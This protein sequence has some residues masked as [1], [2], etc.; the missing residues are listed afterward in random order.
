MNVI[1][2]KYIDTCVNCPDRVSAHIYAKK[3]PT[4][5]FFLV[6]YHP[7]T[8]KFRCADRICPVSAVLP[9]YFV[10]VQKPHALSELILHLTSLLATPNTTS[11][12]KTLIPR[13]KPHITEKIPR[14]LT[15]DPVTN[16]AASLSGLGQFVLGP[17]YESVPVSVGVQQRQV[18][19]LDNLP[20][21]IDWKFTA[22]AVI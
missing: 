14:Y 13:Y 21:R 9:L 10:R 20:L 8:I 12:A 19:H 7:S 4:N 16:R 17:A 2:W 6:S 15:L 5:H 11:H 22:L 3:C 1:R 18:H